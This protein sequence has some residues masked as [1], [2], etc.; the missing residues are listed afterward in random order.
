MVE[1]DSGVDKSMSSLYR[2]PQEVVDMVVDYVVELHSHP[3]SP[4]R[5][6]LRNASLA[7][8]T[9]KALTKLSATS[10]LFRRQC[11]VHLFRKLDVRV[12]EAYDEATLKKVERTLNLFK[13]APEL[14]TFVR[15]LCIAMDC[16][17]LSNDH[18]ILDGPIDPAEW[19]ESSRRMARRKAIQSALA[20]V[21]AMLGKLE[22]VE[23]AH[24]P[25]PFHFLWTSTDDWR[26]SVE[27]GA[28]RR[29]L[30][31]ALTRMVVVRSAETLRRLRISGFANVPL[32]MLGRLRVLEDLEIPSSTTTLAVSEEEEVRIPWKLSSLNAASAL[33]VLGSDSVALSGVY[34]QLTHLRLVI[35]TVE[36]YSLAW[37]IITSAR[38][39]LISVKL[40][41]SPHRS[42]PNLGTP[43][44]CYIIICL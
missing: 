32:R 6:R 16:G 8:R 25:M 31:K 5:P 29:E 19:R 17:N 30:R 11:L 28:V 12:D 1:A 33:D 44:L 2:L 42:E 10:R 15:E 34:H 18:P 20:K 21:L 9:V 7:P 37:N 24:V 4:K 23:I 43:F 13:G 26:R 14:P 41:Y 38:E 39:T 27:W 22:G 40:D 3:S 35:G 36:G